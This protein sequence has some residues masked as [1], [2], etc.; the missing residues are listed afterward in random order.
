MDNEKTTVPSPSA[1]TDGEQPLVMY[2]THTIPQELPDGNEKDL[3]Q[4]IQEM[5]DSSRLQTF[6]LN[7]LY[8]K[9][10]ESRPPVIDGLLYPGTYLFVGAPKVGKSFLMAQIAYHVSTGI[11]L[12]EL[13][14]RKGTVLYLALEDSGKRLQSRLYRMFGT[15]STE[16]LHFALYAKSLGGGLIEQ[17][18]RFLEQ[19]EDTNLVIIDTLQRIREAGGDKYSYGADYATIQ[20]LKQFADAYGICLLIVHHTRK[21]Q[22][23]DHFDMI[24]GTNGLLGAADG[25]FLLQKEKRTGDE[26]TL[27]ISGRDQQEQRFHLKRDSDRLTW[28][29]VHKET[30]LWKAPPDPVLEAVQNFVLSNGNWEGSPS[31]L[32]ALLALDMKP[33]KLSQHLNIHAA[34]LQNEYGTRYESSRTHAGRSIRLRPA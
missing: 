25:A 34:R 5:G 17:L 9:V 30:E 1:A 13:S 19:H 32:A 21:Q 7:E 16:Q 15:E 33:N 22:A 10:Y 3:W 26:A 14:V 31:Q 4:E 24:S 29:L 12:W 28:E 2:D 23:E 27:E 18:E 6:S 20:K 11:P 8:E